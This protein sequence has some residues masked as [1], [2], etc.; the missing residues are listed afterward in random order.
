MYMKKT[1]VALLDISMLLLDIDYT[2]SS[3]S[4]QMNIMIHQGQPQASL[5]KPYKII[6]GDGEYK[7]FKNIR[8]IQNI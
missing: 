6:K 5:S 8:L 3:I 1:Y 4:K 7:H 2:A